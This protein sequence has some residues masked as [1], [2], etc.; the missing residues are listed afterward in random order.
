MV[1]PIETLTLLSVQHQR[2]KVP[3]KRPSSVSLPSALISGAEAA[4]LADQLIKAYRDVEPTRPYAPVRQNL[5]STNLYFA[6]LMA[7]RGWF[8]EADRSFLKSLETAARD[9]VP[10]VPAGDIGWVMLDA[11]KIYVAA[12]GGGGVPAAS[13]WQTLNPGDCGRPTDSHWRIA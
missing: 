4:A 5:F 10:S 3:F 9:K 8:S 2:L 13:V 1:T 12:K 11:E 6:R 7:D